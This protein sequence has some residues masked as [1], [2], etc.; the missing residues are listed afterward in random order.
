MKVKNRILLNYIIMFV[1][2]TTI[3]IIAFYAI[4]LVSAFLENSLVKNKYTAN[5]LMKDNIDEIQYEDV[6]KYNGGLHILDKDY[7]VIYSKGINGFP[8]SKLSASEFTDFLINSQSISR[9]YSYSIAY[10]DNNNFWLIVTFPTSVRIDFNVA[11]NNLYSSADIKTVSLFMALLVLT[12]LL[13]L[14][15]ST[16]IYSRITAKSF[17][18]PLKRLQNFAFNIRKGNYSTRID[19]R[20]KNEFGDLEHAFNEMA[21]KIQNEIE[22]RE[23]SEN[24]RKQLTA[25]IAHD[26][27][28]PLAVISG[29]VEYCLNNPGEDNQKYLEL[30]HEKCICADNLIKDLMELSKLESPEYKMNLNRTDISEYLRIK[31]AQL[32]DLLDRAEFTY[33]FDIPETEVY[34]NL[35][36]KEMDRV[37]DNLASN[38]IRYNQ[39][40]TR[41]D[42][43]LREEKDKVQIIFK[44]DEKGIPKDLCEDIFRPFVRTDNSRNSRTGGSGLGLSIAEKIVKLHGG[45]ILLKSDI[46]EGCLFTIILPKI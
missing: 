45:E 46:G 26:I 37:F 17:I 25:N 15:I 23:K 16:L 6:L 9:K 2:S 1:I 11:H 4:T 43:I 19:V 34:I 14:A 35:D 41:I 27:R 18:E 12:Y 28:N 24:L 7:N 10:N 36:R 31:A 32:V 30:I 42:L 38:A 22:L 40:G 8:K 21:D 20:E 29:Y 33:D 39:K 13:M 44:D 3:A 5:S